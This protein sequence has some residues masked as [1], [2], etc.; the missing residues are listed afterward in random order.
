VAAP[1]TLASRPPGRSSI[2]PITN[3]TLLASI[4]LE[5][6]AGLLLSDQLPSRALPAFLHEATH[7]WCFFSA[8]GA[9]VTLLAMHARR[10]AL[11]RGVDPLDVLDDY[12]R[13]DALM[14]AQAPLSEGIAM[15][16]E[17]DAL[18]G[19]SPVASDVMVALARFVRP[20]GPDADL[21]ET[22]RGTLRHHRSTVRY[23][24]RK[25]S[26]LGQP[27]RL[28][29]GGYLAGYL[30]VKGMWRDAAAKNH[31]L[32]DSD[33]FL[34]LLVN[35]VYQD[36][37]LVAH[38]LDPDT[39]DFDAAGRIVN[40]FGARL[41]HFHEAISDELLDA[42]EAGHD[43]PVAER[44][45]AGGLEALLAEI[46]NLGTDPDLFDLGRRRLLDA[47][48]IL[49]EDADGPDPDLSLVARRQLWA[50]SERELLCVGR[51]DVELDITAS[52]WTR[53][54]YDGAM[55]SS[56]RAADGLAA[57][58][59][60]PGVLE[61]Y[62]N[63]WVWGRYMAYS[64]SRD[65]QPVITWFNRELAPALVEQF[66]GYVTDSADG[67]ALDEQIAEHVE[68][69]LAEYGT[70]QIVIPEIRKNLSGWI[71]HVFLRAALPFVDGDRRAVAAD[72]MA[73][74][75]L[76]PVLG[77]PLMRALAWLSLNWMLY[78]GG[79]LE[80]AFRAAA[81]FHELDQDVWDVAAEIARRA[82][83]AVGEPLVFVQD[84]HVYCTV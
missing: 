4:R 26:L 79:E 51:L 67:R 71:E 24:A 40:Y 27:L 25:T 62:L 63:P 7:H 69:L 22:I 72:L 9:A 54:W 29:A 21:W 65:G 49:E 44:D 70:A 11:R 47:R 74:D 45:L 48:R 64:V 56:G 16:A 3:V 68:E 23:G 32:L 10:R 1:E 6:D 5:E 39:S 66:Q 57:C 17:F 50:L 28:D 33:L 35:Y 78:G 61:I 58:E 53:I 19:S 81:V 82:E 34:K 41:V 77:L 14:R 75:G 36:L 84:D 42:I 15:F 80:A 2:D 38:L 8:A 73:V 13:Y 31:R 55:I 52:G 37:G 30:L 76:E 46:P 83:E 18:P 59:R 20:E 43:R 12:V 60:G